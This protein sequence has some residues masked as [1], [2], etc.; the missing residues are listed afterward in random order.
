[1]ELSEWRA[2]QAQGEEAELPS[3]LVVRLRRVGMMDLAVAG[4]VPAPLAGALETMMA[5]KVTLVTLPEFERY[6]GV[7]NLVVRAAV[8][9][10]EIGEEPGPNRLAVTELPMADRIAIFNWA[11]GGATQLKPFRAP[12]A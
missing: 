5:G 1:M 8:V 2:R 3:G 4:G 9:E 11:N 10:P 7:V 12:S 6:A